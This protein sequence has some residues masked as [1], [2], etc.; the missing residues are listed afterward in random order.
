VAWVLG[1]FPARSEGWSGGLLVTRADGSLAIL[2][3]HMTQV[4][5]VSSYIELSLE[6]GTRA[7]GESLEVV[8][9]PRELR[10]PVA[11]TS[12]LDPGFVK[13]W[14]PGPGSRD[15][16]SLQRL[17][18][19]GS[20]VLSMSWCPDPTILAAACS[21]S[22]VRLWAQRP[23]SGS[24]A[25]FFHALTVQAPGASMLRSIGWLPDGASSSGKSA[26]LTGVSGNGKVHAWTMS[27][28]RASVK[29]TPEL[30][31]WGGGKSLACGPGHGGGEEVV[32]GTG[33]N[34]SAWMSQDGTLHVLICTKEQ[35]FLSGLPA[36]KSEFAQ[37]S[38]YTEGPSFLRLPPISRL[39]ALENDA[40]PQTSALAA[41]HIDGSYSLW[42]VEG[43]VPC[44]YIAGKNPLGPCTSASWMPIREGCLPTAIFSCGSNLVVHQLNSA[45]GNTEPPQMVD[46]D[47]A[48][49][50]SGGHSSGCCGMTV[51]GVVSGNELA[52]LTL[53]LRDSQIHACEWNFDGAPGAS[54][55]TRCISTA[56]RVAD[57]ADLTRGAI[58]ALSFLSE[59]DFV[60]ALCVSGAIYVT[61]FRA[62]AMPRAEGS[63][64]KIEELAS[65]SFEVEGVGQ[66]D[67]LDISPWGCHV[68]LGRHV[69]NDAWVEIYHRFTISS[70]DFSLENKIH[71]TGNAG[72]D[73]IKFMKRHLHP[74]AVMILQD[75]NAFVSCYDVKLAT[76]G[77]T[78]Q[79]VNLNQPVTAFC[80]LHHGLAVAAGDEIILGRIAAGSH[81]AREIDAEEGR[82]VA[83]L[84]QHAVQGDRVRE[85]LCHGFSPKGPFAPENL[86][87]WLR[88][89]KLDLVRLALRSMQRKFDGTSLL[90]SIAD[91]RTMS[92]AFS[93]F[94]IFDVSESASISSILLGDE[95][96][97]GP[98]DGGTDCLLD[99]LSKPFVKDEVQQLE[100][101]FQ[102]SLE[103]L[104]PESKASL[105]RLYAKVLSVAQ[106]LYEIDAGEAVGGLDR[107]ARHVYICHRIVKA[108]RSMGEKND[109]YNPDNGLSDNDSED[110]FLSGLLPASQIA[111]ALLSESKETLLNACIPRVGSNWQMVK[112]IGGAYWLDQTVLKKT[113]EGLA[114]V[115]YLE[116][117]DP[118][119]SALM[120]IALNRKNVLA[121]LCRTADQPRLL[122]FFSR[123]FSDPENK[124]AALKN[125]YVLLSQHRY[126]LSAAFFILGGQRSDAYEILGG[127]AG[128]FQLAFA[129]AR[130]LEGDSGDGLQEFINKH[131][132]PHA[133]SS[134]NLWFACALELFRGNNEEAIR[135]V[136][137]ESGGSAFESHKLQSP[138]EV[139]GFCRNFLD[140]RPSATNV[141]NELLRKHGHKVLYVL[142]RTG[143]TVALAH[144]V[145]ILPK[146][147]ESRVAEFLLLSTLVQL[148]EFVA[149]LR[150]ATGE[151]EVHCAHIAHEMSSNLPSDNALRVATATSLFS[152]RPFENW[153]AEETLGLGFQRSSWA[154]VGGAPKGSSRE[155]SL[156]GSEITP[157]CIG[158]ALEGRIFED[159][160]DCSIPGHLFHSV[161]ASSVCLSA[162]ASTQKGLQS[163]PARPL[164][165]L[166]LFKNE[167]LVGRRIFFSGRWPGDNWAERSSHTQE[168][169]PGHVPAWARL[170]ISAV[171]VE[172][173]CLEAHPQRP[174]YL[175]GS[176]GEDIYLWQF[177]QRSAMATYDA[178]DSNSGRVTDLSFH[179]LGE[180]FAS[181]AAS[182]TVS[183]WHLETAGSERRVSSIDSSA[184]PS[185]GRTHYRS[186]RFLGGSSS[187]LLLSGSGS[188]G[189]SIWDSLSGRVFDIRNAGSSNWSL[190][191]AV[192]VPGTPFVA[193]VSADGSLIVADLRMISNGQTSWR[194]GSMRQASALW[195]SE[196]AHTGRVTSILA[197][198]E[199]CAHHRVEEGLLLTGG[200]DSTVK[201]WDCKSSASNVQ[202]AGLVQE[203]E[204][205]K[206]K[207][208]GLQP[209]TLVGNISQGI[210]KGPR[211]NPGG[212]VHTL[213][214]GPLGLYVCSAGSIAFLRFSARASPHNASSQ[215]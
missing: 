82:F 84:G 176:K 122:Q 5:G 114:K 153:G 12:R 126:E 150:T 162:V 50:P 102:P 59:G 45:G 35:A 149:Q 23:S 148:T 79:F 99:R 179:V 66:I 135:Y 56:S 133:L 190:N 94:S 7:S 177:Q 125:A 85:I 127:N 120:Y 215:L 184:G 159:P 116:K 164:S 121:A 152:Q 189:L 193:M 14:S 113:L 97:K 19:N 74:A 42:K 172:A 86:E 192:T 80:T 138:S 47:C 67:A 212:G 31:P 34:S 146:H 195:R 88:L 119:D 90:K 36:P 168:L 51:L 207:Y 197:F 81:T 24:T 191:K 61:H 115:R 169:S 213:S 17:D 41:T 109:L 60:T 54:A 76:W 32:Q 21:D 175:S 101:A 4:V 183:L 129:V 128:D 96:Q 165:G 161:C 205:P 44:L 104:P 142:Q 103:N 46:L 174:L 123:D 117:K 93:Y 52:C 20:H 166:H 37:I 185:A 73:S 171:D 53:L 29:A 130:V 118:Q 196:T 107:A 38:R 203:V 69:R 137:G 75:G 110:K 40:E 204:V 105:A 2:L 13:V 77:P 132:I 180:R 201:V 194:S 158:H 64:Q 92:G 68:A 186:A 198:P 208:P 136:F 3:V 26:T 8:A 170:S 1:G 95:F 78:V 28:N 141:V 30:V 178:G 163:L 202:A 139:P 210:S 100:N 173:E 108:R 156:Q 15:E 18:H 188:P 62:P 9:P 167:D 72:I 70:E 43:G 143:Q 33:V 157:R 91:S 134:G 10:S 63:V 154:S 48:L 71:L 144:A 22:A 83:R 160:Q 16:P 49:L 200:S 124:K 6:W 187:T 39:T 199:Y 11:S 112:D 87:M 111:W 65:S 145:K 147:S 89:G 106:V 206:P 181:V 57:T 155:A 214:I 211:T 140:K 58:S 209:G 151:Q 182:G 55:P 98:R 131:M 27:V 25:G